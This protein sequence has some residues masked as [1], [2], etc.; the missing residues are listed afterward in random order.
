MTGSSKVFCPK[1]KL[2]YGGHYYRK[3]KGVWVCDFCK[4]PR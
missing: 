1:N 3:V 4:E 2:R